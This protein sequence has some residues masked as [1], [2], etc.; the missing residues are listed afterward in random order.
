LPALVTAR[1]LFDMVI[2]NAERQRRYIGRLKQKAEQADD[3]GW[4]MAKL[5]PR[6]TG[7][8]MAVWLTEN[9]GY[10]HDVRVKVSRL[11]GGGG[12]WRHDSVSVTVRPRV[13]QIPPD[14]LPSDDFLAVTLWIKLNHQTII[15][16]W[17]GKLSLTE[18]LGLLQ[19]LP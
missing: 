4:A 13:R 8:P 6:E 17:D 9:D 16:Y 18:L 14:S 3:E 7:L 12:S 15:D 5:L 11:H 19:K 10:P 1:I 2:S